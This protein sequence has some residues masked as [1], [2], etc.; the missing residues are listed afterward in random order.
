MT[1]ATTTPQ[2]TPSQ[3]MLERADRLHAASEEAVRTRN[4]HFEA[5]NDALRA[6]ESWP[7]MR[8]TLEPLA[9]TAR[10]AAYRFGD[11]QTTFFQSAR[12]LYAQAAELESEEREQAAVRLRD[13]DVQFRFK[14]AAQEAEADKLK[15]EEAAQAEAKLKAEAEAK[16]KAEEAAE[17]EAKLQAAQA[18]GK[19]RAATAADKIEAEVAKLRV[20]T[21]ADKLKDAWVAAKAAKDAVFGEKPYYCETAEMM[22]DSARQT[23]KEAEAAAQTRD[24]HL[25]T[26][27]AAKLDMADPSRD[28]T[29]AYTRWLAATKNAVGFDR[30]R[31]SQLFTAATTYL[32]ASVVE[33]E[34]I[35]STAAD[36]AAAAAAAAA[37]KTTTA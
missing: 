21:A 22:R 36:A 15:A 37:N 31:E 4:K 30:M 2:K 26:A 6:I 19:L 20:A 12:S 9:E 17:A 35:A 3:A 5:R 33:A 16:L 28:Y 18:V 11:L 25:E 27:K 23:E 10:A 14:T 8:S 13:T 24:K 7:E 1:D 29:V 34:E 32:K